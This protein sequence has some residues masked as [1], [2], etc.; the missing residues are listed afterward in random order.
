MNIYILHKHV[1]AKNVLFD[2]YIDSFFSNLTHFS[3]IHQ[4]HV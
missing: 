1:F 3:R 4:L 2:S